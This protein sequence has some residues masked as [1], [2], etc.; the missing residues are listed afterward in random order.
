MGAEKLTYPFI[1]LIPKSDTTVAFLMFYTRITLFG[2]VY[3][4]NIKT[5]FSD[6]FLNLFPNMFI[7][8]FV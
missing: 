7:L 5:L 3:Q 2:T 8:K 4:F 1:Y 6:E